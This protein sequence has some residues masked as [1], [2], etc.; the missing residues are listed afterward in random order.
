MSEEVFI[1]GL[2]SGIMSLAFAWQVFSR[3]D[4]EIGNDAATEEG[5]KYLPYV[6]GAL[7]PVCLLTLTILA[8]FE[9][10]TV[11]AV[12][13]TFS[14]C[15]SIFL[16][17]CL[18]YLVLLIILPYLR[19]II[20]ARACAMLWLIPNYLYILF[21]GHLEPPGP[22]LVITA[23]G[24]SAYIIFGVWI[25]GF[26]GVMIWKIIDH[27]IFRRR[28]LRDAKPVTNA[29]VI[30]VWNTL[31][32]DA[33]FRKPKFKLISSSA[34]STPLTIGLFQ[35]TT[36]V[37]L[38]ENTYA[39]EDLELILRHELV[40]IGRGDAWNKF[41]M[42]FC[43]AMCWFNPLMWVA[44]RKS[45]DDLE[46]SC[47]ETVLLDTDDA[48]RKQYAILLLDTAG[49]ERG[50]TTC[51]SATA[52]AMRYRLRSV[53]KPGKRR[54]GALI[55]GAVFFFLCMTSGYVA[56]AYDGNSGAQMLYQGDDFTGYT[57][58][59]VSMR[60]DNFNTQ[61]EIRDEA[62]FHEYLAGLTVYELTGNYSFR[63]SER[64]YFVILDTPTLSQVFTLYDD[65][66]KLVWLHQIDR[67]AEYYYVPGGLDWDYI[68]TIIV[69]QPA[70]NVHLTE[71]GDAYGRDLHTWVNCIWKTENGERV[72]IHETDYPDGE[73]HGLFTHEP[74]PHEATF[75][76]SQELAAPF[77][78]LVESWD[79]STSYTVSQAEMTDEFTIAL[80]DYPA[81]YTVYATFWRTD[82]AQYEVEF[83][84]NIGAIDSQ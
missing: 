11:G 56:L 19:K 52:K 77:S 47:D 21:N 41:F 71:E 3:Y 51:L 5:Q 44:M 58:R 4:H 9:Y 50:F 10:G 48:T 38:P 36:R 61:F 6:N 24:K 23:P 20:S 63:D 39:K 64:Y 82:G 14:G 66:I 79:Y 49:D 31:I 25:F 7:L 18:Y 27:L 37:V 29:N 76:F 46:L 17:I 84:F 78:V 62:A 33:N 73:H 65:V 74:Y 43:T 67:P 13:V 80:P 22:L 54:S 2:F 55:V 12:R 30:D 81:H 70:L 16:Q 28:I 45:A 75:L 34:V 8:F 83:W 72:L 1:R 40:H 15:F 26:T 57:I 68:D 59:D 32:E 53:T 60:D 35:R 69:P 42:V